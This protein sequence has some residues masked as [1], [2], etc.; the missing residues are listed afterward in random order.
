MEDGRRTI[1]G[2]SVSLSEAEVH[3]RKF[4]H[5]LKE[6]GMYGTVL[7]VSDAHEG[8]KSALKATLPGVK[9]QRCQFHLQRSA[10]SYITKHDLKGEVACDIRAIFNAPS[11]EEAHRLLAIVV[12]KYAKTQSKLSAWMEDNLPEGLAVFSLPPE[13]RRRLRTTN[14]VENLNRQ[15]RRRTRISG[16]FPNEAS[17]LRLVSAILSETSDEWEAGPVYLNVTNI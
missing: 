2:A 10:Q 16:L 1:L 15:I 3:W 7:V 5:S 11:L 6:R 17:L 9:W 8:L 4:L 14:A 13:T 12:E